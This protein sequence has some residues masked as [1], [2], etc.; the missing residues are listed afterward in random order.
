MLLLFYYKTYFTIGNNHKQVIWIFLTDTLRNVNKIKFIW[1]EICFG[2]FIYNSYF[3][4]LV[5]WK[6]F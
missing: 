5:A 6:Q 1:Y 3:W 2:L 4:A